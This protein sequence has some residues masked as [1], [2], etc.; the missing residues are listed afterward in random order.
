ML[1]RTSALP[2]PPRCSPAAAA[3][4]EYGGLGLGSI[5]G[6]IIGEN[7]AWGCTGMMTAIEGN[8]LAEAPVILA[9]SDAQKKKYLGRMTEAPLQAAYCVT[10][11]GAGSDVAGIQTRAVK[12]GD[13][14]VLNGNKMWIT[15]GGVA[16][17]FFV[18]A[19]SDPN[20][21][22]GKA[23]TA[24]IMDADTPGITV[25]RKEINMGQRCSDTRGITFEDVEVPDAN[26]IGAWHAV[27]CLAVPRTRVHSSAAQVMWAS[28]SRWPWAPLTRRAPLW[29]P[30]LWGWRS[31]Q[32][33]RRP[34][35]RCSARRWAA[36]SRSTRCGCVGAL[37]SGVCTH[38]HCPRQ[39]VAFMLADMA[40]GV[41]AARLL[42][43]KSA[44]EID[45]GRRNTYWASVAKAFAADHCNKVVSDAV[46]VC[47]A[48]HCRAR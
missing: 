20:E 17:W 26:R 39:A 38:A 48:P 4:Q 8:G 35:M 18:L 33:T 1:C 21:R 11:P 42:T 6:C 15:N 45:Q 28:A 16:N 13:K 7:L 12:K 37:G 2:A 34:P 29:R 14:W 41:E 31:A 5:E 44:Y 3:W 43:L 24:F 40:I 30:A 32:W 46:Q 25:G 10:E 19:K 47:A 22:A 9:A 27:A 36:P 23:F